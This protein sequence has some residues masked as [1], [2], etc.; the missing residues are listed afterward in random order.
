M[1][2]LDGDG[3]SQVERAHCWDIQHVAVEYIAEYLPGREDCGNP[4]R[5]LGCR[6]WQE[7][8][9]RRLPVRIV[10][11]PCL[12]CDTDYRM[13]TTMGIYARKIVRWRRMAHVVQHLRFGANP[14]SAAIETPRYPGHPRRSEAW[15]RCH[16]MAPTEPRD[17]AGKKTSVYEGLTGRA[18]AWSAIEVDDRRDLLVY[19]MY[20]L[21]GGHDRDIDL[22]RFQPRQGIHERR[23]Y[24]Y[25]G[26]SWPCR[27]SEAM[28]P[29]CL[30][31]DRGRDTERQCLGRRFQWSRAAKV[32]A[33]CLLPGTE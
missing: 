2:L 29:L 32:S 33:P 20:A 13:L 21:G 25:L 23:C 10:F 15:H 1:G 19:W 14:L 4:G 22:G 7:S 5:S 31:G 17:R 11:V 26:R 18:V 12:Y 3:P 30:E 28:G 6:E 27:A 24:C 8:L 16:R 9:G